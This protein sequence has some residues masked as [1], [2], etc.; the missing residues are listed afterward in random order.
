MFEGDTCVIAST[1]GDVKTAQNM[2]KELKKLSEANLS[3][4]TRQR[5]KTAVREFKKVLSQFKYLP[6]ST[7]KDKASKAER[8]VAMQGYEYAC[9]LSANRVRSSFVIS[10]IYSILGLFDHIPAV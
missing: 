3:E 6:P 1:M 5:A 2:V 9:I 10:M 8:T 7:K 4:E